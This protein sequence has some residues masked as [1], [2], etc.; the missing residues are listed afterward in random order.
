MT[1]IPSENELKAC[2]DNYD[3]SQLEAY[4]QTEQYRR[5]GGLGD[6]VV[7]SEQKPPEGIKHKPIKVC[8][9]VLSAELSEQISRLRGLLTILSEVQGVESDFVHLGHYNERFQ[10]FVVQDE[11]GNRVKYNLEMILPEF[12]DLINAY[13]HE[14]HGEFKDM[15]QWTDINDDGC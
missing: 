4:Y 14:N 2:F 6:M 7:L 8:F 12:S 3:P 11:K 9:T 1:D 13:V 15:Y 10:S 5:Y